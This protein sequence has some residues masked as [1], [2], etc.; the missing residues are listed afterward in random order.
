MAQFQR[1]KTTFSKIGESFETRRNG[2]SRSHSDLFR[3][4]LYWTR[5][6]RRFNR[7]HIRRSHSLVRFKQWITEWVPKGRHPDR[8][9]RRIN[10]SSSS[11]INSLWPTECLY[12][13]KKCKPAHSERWNFECWILWIGSMFEVL[14][15]ES[16]KV[17][18]IGSSITECSWDLRFEYHGNIS[19]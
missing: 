17:K 8:A 19:I 1:G 5:S 18:G 14:S 12:W 6:L 2:S 11:W 16:K 3:N 13:Q 4:S 10:A 9:W 7:I 15:L